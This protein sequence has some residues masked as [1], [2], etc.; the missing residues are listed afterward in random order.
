LLLLLLFALRSI[1]SGLAA[2]KAVSIEDLAKN[3][4]DTWNALAVNLQRVGNLNCSTTQ[5]ITQYLLL[6]N[7]Y[8]FQLS[9]RHI[10]V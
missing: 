8:S 3:A 2:L 7:A 1:C 9:D 6:L 5:L 4:G 10:R